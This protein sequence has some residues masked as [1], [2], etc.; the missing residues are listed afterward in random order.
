MLLFFLC[1]KMFLFLIR[2]RNNPQLLFWFPAVEGYFWSFFVSSIILCTCS[3]Y[4]FSDVCFSELISDKEFLSLFC[5]FVNLFLLLR[6]SFFSFCSFF[7]RHPFFGSG[8][9]FYF[10]IFI[11]PKPS[12]VLPVHWYHLSVSI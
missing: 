7:L 4:R 6:S 10:V 11:F 5:L 1:I 3:F 2:Q 9:V 12:G 8:T